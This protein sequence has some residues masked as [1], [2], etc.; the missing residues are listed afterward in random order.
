MIR[1]SLLWL[2][3]VGLLAALP[4]RAAEE[5]APPPDQA[6]SHEDAASHEGGHDAPG[7]SPDIFSGT[8]GTAIL[9]LAI[10]IVLLA[11]L[12]KWAWGPILSGLQKREEHI[13]RSIEDAE[14][15]RAQAEE[16]LAQYQEQLA[17]ANREAQGIIDQGRS[18]AAKLAEQ[19]KQNAQAE[20][21]TLRQ[22]AQQDIESAKQQALRDLCDQTCELAT[23]IAG[24]ILKRSLNPQDHR[25][26][27]N[28]AINHLQS[29]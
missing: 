15:A 21:Q 3:C 11:V 28:D 1:R 18:D 9:T 5:T 26:L 7:E 16:A 22:Q 14:H 23:D 25:D 10:F 8:W 24:K 2:A 6:A 13:R 17:Q 20:A 12:G 27:L 19:L 29:N 4:V